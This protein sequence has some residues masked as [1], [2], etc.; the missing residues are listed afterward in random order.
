MTR[1]TAT[2]TVVVMYRIEIERDL[3]DFSATEFVVIWQ[4]SESVQEVS[5]TLGIPRDV[6]LRHEAHLRQWIPEMKR[7]GV[8]V[9]V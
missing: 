8:M 9:A 6:V 3:Y 2:T 1:E 7:F 5:D 4:T